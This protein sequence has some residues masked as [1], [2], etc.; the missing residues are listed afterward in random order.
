MTIPLGLRDRILSMY[1]EA[2]D[3]WPVPTSEL[4]LPTR[5]GSIHVVSTGPED[6]PFAVF[7][8]G[9]SFPAP[10]T[11][12]TLEKPFLVSHRVIAPDTIGDVGKSE[13]KSLKT[14]PRSGSDYARWVEDVLSQLVPA[15]RQIDIIG[16]SYG[17]WIVPVPAAARV[18]AEI[19][20]RCGVFDLNSGCSEFVY[21][22]AIADGLLC[23]GMNKVLLAASDTVSRIVDPDDRAT[24]VL[25][26]DAGGAVVLEAVPGPGSLLSYDL[27]ADGNLG[28]LIYQNHGGYVVM[29]GHEVFRRAVRATASSATVALERAKVTAADVRLF[30]PHQAN[31]RIME[32]VGAR[33]GIEPERT[34][35]VVNWTGNTS[36]A[37]IPFALTEAADGGRLHPGRHLSR[38]AAASSPRLRCRVGL[39]TTASNKG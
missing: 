15:N 38:A 7:F 35:V 19:G 31:L 26:G 16:A 23:R 13:L 4:T 29:D 36:S 34:M 14:R 32:A 5:Y 22:L 20:L 21:G 6:G 37:S 33:L 24:A 9:M 25:F 1:Q 27:G 3:F 10:L 11:W 39:C 30:I 18:Q 17:A 2:L 8:H 12:A 28:D